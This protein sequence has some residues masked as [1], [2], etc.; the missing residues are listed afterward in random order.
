M[1]ADYRDFINYTLNLFGYPAK[2]RSVCRLDLIEAP[3]LG[4]LMAKIR[5]LVK[6]TAGFLSVYGHNHTTRSIYLHYEFVVLDR[7]YANRKIW[8]L[9][10]LHSPKGLE[11]ANVGRA[12]IKGILHS[13]RG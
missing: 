1:A 8:S 5:R 2:D 3:H 4:N 9:I 11:W 12:F 10:R 6:S 13:A 7:P